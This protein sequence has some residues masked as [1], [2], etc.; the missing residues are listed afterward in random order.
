MWVEKMSKLFCG[1]DGYGGNCYGGNKGVLPERGKSPAP[2]PKKTFGEELYET[3][4]KA[5]EKIHQEAIKEAKVLFSC[6]KDKLVEEANKGNSAYIIP[7]DEFKELIEE[8][9]LHSDTFTLIDI[10]W[11]FLKDMDIRAYYKNDPVYEEVE[12]YGHTITYKEVGKEERVVF[13][14]W[15]K[16]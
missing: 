14:W 3:T 6:I 15:R 10:M 4:K 8:N 2:A 13:E 1:N 12:R 7:L 5:K 16:K 11:N 9:D